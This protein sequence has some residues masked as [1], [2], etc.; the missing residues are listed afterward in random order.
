MYEKPSSVTIF[1][2]LSYKSKV[3]YAFKQSGLPGLIGGIILS[4]LYLKL[5]PSKF[6]SKN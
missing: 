3:L 5:L 4:I 2:I 6:F 1:L